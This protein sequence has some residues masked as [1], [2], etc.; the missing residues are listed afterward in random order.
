MKGLIYI[1][2]PVTLIFCS[3]V[4]TT[5]PLLLSL[6]REPL[7]VQDWRHMEKVVPQLGQSSRNAQESVPDPPSSKEAQER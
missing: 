6:S 4:E 2:T 3:S 1:H 5:V 7:R